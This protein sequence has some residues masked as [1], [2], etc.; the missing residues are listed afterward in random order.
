MSDS[1]SHI[2]FQVDVSRIIEVLAKQIYQSPLALLRE[3]AQNAFDAILLRRHLGQPFQPRIDIDIAANEI[4]IR[5]N[6]IG[7]TAEDLRTHYWNAGSSSKNTAEARAAGVVGTF[8]IGAMANFGIASELRIETESA[9]TTHRTRSVARKEELSASKD[10]IS[11]EPLPS[12]GS[13]GTTVH[14]AV[15]QGGIN[16]TEAVAYISDFVAHVDIPVYVNGTVMS[17]RDPAESVPFGA[18]TETLDLAVHLPP[19]FVADLR[20]HLASNGTLAVRVT[21]LEYRGIALQGECLFRQG[22]SSIRTFRSGFGLAT[23]AASSYYQLGGIANLDLFQP[24]AGREALTTESI[25]ALQSLVSALD[26]VLSLFIAPRPEADSNSY[27]IEWARVHGRFDLCGQLCAR[28]QPNEQR[29][30]LDVLRGWLRPV[31]VYAGSDQTIIGATA[32]DD[33][34]L[35]VLA[36]GNPRRQC[37]QEFIRQ[38]CSHE[39]IDDVPKVL[40]EKP[41]S[42][43]TIEEQAIVFRV[44]NVLEADYFVPSVVRL[45]QLSHSLPIV[46]Q[47][48]HDPLQIVLDPAAPTFGVVQELYKSDLQAFGS[49]VKDFVRNIVFQRISDRVPSSTREGAEAFLK[50]IRRS[51]DVFEYEADDTD[52]LQALWSEYLEGHLTMEQVT[53][54]SSALVQQSIQVVDSTTA[55]FV[56]DVVP[57]VLANEQTLVG[58]GSMLG[59]L[60]P[61]LRT[62]IQSDAKLLTI[63]ANDPALKG[64]RCF[65]AI[66]DRVRTEHGEFFLQPHSTSVVWGGQ[67]VLFVFQHHSGQFGLYYDLQTPQNVAPE[68]GGGPVTT[69]TLVLQNRVYIPVPENVAAAFIP[70]PGERKRFEIRCDLIYTQEQSDI[71][72]VPIQS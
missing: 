41:P 67:K 34:P 16:V 3:N 13:A 32:T 33:S 36:S 63:D 14:A 61:I 31:L 29:V 48:E 10:C 58:N 6:G 60:P 55:Q 40:R 44:K 26:Q 42:E 62:E 21:K 57:D 35:V 59:A 54:R 37:E 28:V 71:A 51:R 39:F 15:S 69:A 45:G 68:S 20:V 12:I 38:Y 64:Y 11:L 65:L 4:T 56:R 24:T 22:A 47:L 25:Q 5:D 50:S 53:V 18:G 2:P 7:M 52:S 72:V 27:F 9:I 1:V 43:W 8:G 49:M 46:A 30:M 70:A 23:L 66:S 17:Q 19:D